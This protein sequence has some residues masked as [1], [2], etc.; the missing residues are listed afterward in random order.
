M[1]VLDQIKQE[2]LERGTGI[3]GFP[4]GRLLGDAL[5]R[6]P[7]RRTAGRAYARGCALSHQSSLRATAKQSRAAER[8]MVRDCFAAQGASR[9]DSA[10][11]V[12]IC[13]SPR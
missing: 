6:T 10:N 9:N 4:K 1:P 7:R 13:S 12:G 2:E 5:G 3:G 11:L 8:S